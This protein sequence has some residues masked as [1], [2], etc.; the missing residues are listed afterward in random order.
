MI[1]PNGEVNDTTGAKI[2]RL[3][4]YV[5]KHP[6]I[7]KADPYTKKLFMLEIYLQ[8]YLGYE[9]TERETAVRLFAMIPKEDYRTN[10]RENL[11][12]EQY[13]ANRIKEDYGLNL[14]EFMELPTYR[15]EDIL[16]DQRKIL[17]E[18]RKIREKAKIAAEREKQGLGSHFPLLNFPK[19]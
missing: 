10:S 6:Q 9:I 14:N 17:E 11:R 18:E 7:R 2:N 12:R 5:E 3:V 16:A 19:Q 4:A 8:D 13:K 1:G 15:M